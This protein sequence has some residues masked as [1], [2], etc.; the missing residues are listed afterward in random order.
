MKVPKALTSFLTF[1]PNQPLSWLACVTFVLGFYIGPAVLS[2]SMMVLLGNALLNKNV[3]QI[4]TDTL[5]DRTALLF[6]GFFAFY[7]LSFF[8]SED[9]VYYATRVQL[10]LPFFVLPLAFRAIEWNRS[11]YTSFTF[12]FLSVILLAISWSLYAY[13]QDMEA[14]NASYESAKTLPTPF[15]HIHFGLCV[16]LALSQLPTVLPP[17][18]TQAVLRNGL[19]ATAAFFMLYLHV[20]AAKTPLISLYIL[21]IYWIVRWLRQSRSYLLGGSI[22]VGLMAL[23][24]M[25]YQLSGSFHNKVDYT[26]KSFKRVQKDTME[27]RYS[28]EGRLLSYGVALDVA[29]RYPLL[30]VGVGDSYNEMENEYARQEMVT[31]KVLLP[32]NQ[33]LFILLSLGGLGLLYFLYILYWLFK[34]YYGKEPVLSS[35]LLLF[36]VPLMVEAYLDTQEGIAIFLFFFLFLKRRAELQTEKRL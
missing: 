19:L 22:L 13:A 24:F 8:W 17:K 10:L 34:K 27:V 5:H 9:K 14:I 32:H 21:I 11:F 33:F 7:A 2:V 31:P 26:I 6:A 15:H 28:D 35:F 12:I 25:M 23:P 36:M 18:G 20:L 30:G 1:M 3:K 16:V 29:K 4:I